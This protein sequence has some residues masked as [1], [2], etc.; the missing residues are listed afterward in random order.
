MSKRAIR[1]QSELRFRQMLAEPI[2]AA[3]RDKTKA[4]NEFAGLWLL[5]AQQARPRLI[6]WV[7][8]E[9]FFG[10]DM[11]PVLEDAADDIIEAATEEVLKQVS[12]ERQD[13]DLTLNDNVDLP[14]FLTKVCRKR[15][16]ARDLRSRF[17]TNLTDR[18][19]L[20]DL[21]SGFLRSGRRTAFSATFVKHIL[22]AALEHPR[23]QRRLPVDVLRQRL[24]DEGLL[25]ELVE[26]LWRVLRE[27]GAARIDQRLVKK[28]RSLHL[29]CDILVGPL[30]QAI[31]SSSLL[32][33]T[34]ARRLAAEAL[35]ALESLRFAEAIQPNATSEEDDTTPE[36]LY[37]VASFDFT[38][39][40]ERETFWR[41]MPRDRLLLLLYLQPFDT[42]FSFKAMAL[43]VLGQEDYEALQVDSLAE[44]FAANLTSVSYRG[45][46]SAGDLAKLLG[47]KETTLSKELSILRGAFCSEGDDSEL[48]NHQP[49]ARRA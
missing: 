24:V 8:Q 15:N 37:G 29:T 18:K 47:R 31:V 12:G 6:R 33:A 46:M 49:K 9:I 16:I 41:L 36:Y 34:A 17:V 25:D 3:T 43:G 26:D 23:L 35:F 7:Q 4:L 32:D 28:A 13:A 11:G 1:T 40:S 30:A 44:K 38:D 27:E 22:A 48:E 21:K 20:S 5:V 39:V 45:C 42:V 10:V 2:S 14:L 19:G